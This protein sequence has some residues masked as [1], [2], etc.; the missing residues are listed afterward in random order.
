MAT[1]EDALPGRWFLLLSP[2]LLL[3][4]LLLSGIAS[5]AEV[6]DATGRTVQ[7]LLGSGHAQYRHA[8]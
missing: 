1:K 7:D 8:R 3:L 5:A 4:L 2:L 6:V